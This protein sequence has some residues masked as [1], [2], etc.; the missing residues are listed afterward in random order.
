M[1]VVCGWLPDLFVW[2]L[3]WLLCCVNN[4]VVWDSYVV[5]VACG[6]VVFDYLSCFACGV[7]IAGFGVYCV[8]CMI[9]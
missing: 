4:V 8:V 3:L 1:V 9:A 5:C 6:F 2:L 7:V